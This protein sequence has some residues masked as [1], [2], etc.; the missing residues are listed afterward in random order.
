MP[1]ANGQWSKKRLFGGDARLRGP[2]SSP[3][4]VKHNHEMRRFV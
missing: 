4:S 1:G 2:V 3:S